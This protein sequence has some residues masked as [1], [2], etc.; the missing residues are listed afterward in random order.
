M[1]AILRIF[2]YC[3]KRDNCLSIENRQLKMQLEYLEQY[4]LTNVKH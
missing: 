3:R 2:K 1:K 4:K